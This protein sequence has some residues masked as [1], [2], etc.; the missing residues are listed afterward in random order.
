MSHLLSTDDLTLL[1]TFPLAYRG[2]GQKSAGA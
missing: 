2:G 1:F